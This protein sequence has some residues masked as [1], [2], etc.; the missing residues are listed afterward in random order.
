MFG[1]YFFSHLGTLNWLTVN[2]STYEW[3]H[4][5]GYQLDHNINEE[6]DQDE[7]NIVVFGAHFSRIVSPNLTNIA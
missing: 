5:L 4:K 6:F 3:D 7:P 2:E 1:S